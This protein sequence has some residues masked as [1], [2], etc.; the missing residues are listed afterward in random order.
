[1]NPQ[2]REMMERYLS[3]D[4]AD[5]ELEAFL[6]LIQGDSEAQAELKQAMV[7]QAMLYD[8][9][10]RPNGERVGSRIV[11]NVPTK[12]RSAAPERRASTR[13]PSSVSK[14]LRASTRREALPFDDTAVRRWKWGV[15]AAAVL[16]VL[17]GIFALRANMHSDRDAWL[18][19]QQA[20]RRQE[21]LR[22][23][24]QLERESEAARSIPELPARARKR[25][26]PE[27][28]RP[29]VPIEHR[30]DEEALRLAAE[31]ERKR[32]AEEAARLIDARRQ[33]LLARLK[34]FPTHRPRFDDTDEEP[35]LDRPAGREETASTPTRP[36]AQPEVG[37]VVHVRDE[38]KAGVVVRAV[39]DK[40]VRYGLRKGL[41]LNRGDRIETAVGDDIAGATVE[42]TG[43]AQLD[44]DQK[45]VVVVTESNEARLNTGRIYA[46]VSP[47]RFS[48]TDDSDYASAPP[49][50][51]ETKSG[52]YLT[53]D[54]RAEI[55]ASPDSTT[56]ETRARVDQGRVHLVNKKGLATGHK[57]QEIRSR[58]LLAPQRNDGFSGPIWRGRNLP[59]PG[60]PFGKGNFVIYSNEN[61]ARWFSEDYAMVL[62]HRG[63]IHLVGLQVSQGNLE[64]PRRQ[65]QML[66]QE[67]NL[68]RRM[69]LRNISW[70]A[71]GVPTPLVAPA[72]GKPME[73]RT[74]SS[75]A[76]MQILSASK[77]AS[78][79]RPLVMV[80]TGSL[81]DVASAWRYDA[82]IQD[83]VVVVG[84]FA[85]PG[86][87]WQFDPWAAEIV[88][89]HFRCVLGGGPSLA[90]DAD[91]LARITDR[92][93]KILAGKAAGG[94]PEF[95][96]LAIVTVPGFVQ[97]TR[98]VTFTGIVDGH[99]KFEND[100]K[101]RI[102]L[103][104]KTD[105]DA[106]LRE[107]DQ[108][109]LRSKE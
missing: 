83:K 74:G 72:S 109:F 50:S 5:I 7:Q 108:T 46:C 73:T 40:E 104:S 64:D 84:P 19:E 105:R 101:G 38:Q 78:V 41:R 45:T 4:L 71:M 10:R 1:M 81:T 63:E 34:E 53:Q 37:R 100:P 27:A 51:L 60:L 57:G 97:K 88:L 44:L 39:E 28:P 25:P 17:C 33:Q 12:T 107:F 92:R 62:A 23:I 49:F 58:G 75:A 98:R 30:V 79:E 24:A 8:L 85:R 13:R 48:D 35:E 22:Q 80:C 82:S 21:I 91:R 20:R 54:L 47:H 94:D 61:P 43:G 66:A 29:E 93:W 16:I 59:Y 96:K 68:L 56:P 6:T 106:L 102:W 15:A 70:P 52:R 77:A 2:M 90:V 87:E 67:V 11:P 32:E 36:K 89:G 42:L 18:A 95:S 103:V 86:I 3:D 31:A 14:R 65:F 99:P 55:Y 26:R 9:L 69:G 76:V